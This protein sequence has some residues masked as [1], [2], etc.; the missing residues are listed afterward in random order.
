MKWYLISNHCNLKS[1]LIFK[2]EVILLFIFQSLVLSNNN[3][4]KITLNDI[5]LND[6][7]ISLSGSLGKNYKF[8]SDYID[9][10]T[11]SNKFNYLI[12][13]YS[14]SGYLPFQQIN[15][16]FLHKGKNILLAIEPS[17][18]SSHRGFYINQTNYSRGGISSSLNNAFLR[19]TNQ[20]NNI[21]LLLGRSIFYWGKSQ[22]SS[23]IKGVDSGPVDFLSLNY[24]YKNFRYETLFS[25]LEPL[26]D[27]N[28]NNYNRYFI[29]KRLVY[30]KKRFEVEFGELFL[31]SGIN[32]SFDLRFSTPF[33][34]LFI[35]DLNTS[36]FEISDNYNSI[37]FSSFEF[38]L[39]NELKFFNEIIVDDI[40]I[41][42]TGRDDKLGLKLGFDFA[43]NNNYSLLYEYTNIGKSTYLHSGKFTSYHFYE[44]PI[45]YKYGPD[46]ISHDFLLKINYDQN[47]FFNLGFT[48]LKKGSTNILQNDY[49]RYQTA[50]K[51]DKIVS[52][53]FHF[54]ITTLFRNFI[55]NISCSN[56]PSVNQELSGYIEENPKVGLV[57]DLN[58]F[59]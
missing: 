55:L 6:H 39:S 15:I 20:Y 12:R 48:H 28:E 35:K 26:I 16:R 18:I 56:F 29:G 32:R 22:N 1:I 4:K 53:F 45:G 34:P 57:I 47:I 2:K 23:I 5:G 24:Y 51:N 31:Y 13:N 33:M 58:Y 27:F 49:D 59:K 8:D 52:K 7:F 46:A 37:I 21:S 3:G 41:D 54:G 50:M 30:R 38:N 10:D 11:A 14:R 17:I 19:I 44:R 43:N 42:D 40:Q 25:Q 9:L 36:E